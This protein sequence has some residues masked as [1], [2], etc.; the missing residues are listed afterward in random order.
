MIYDKKAMISTFLLLI[1]CIQPIRTIYSYKSCQHC[2]FYIKPFF[3][4]KYEIGNYLGKCSKFIEMDSYTNQS[5][6]KYALQVRANEN[7]CGQQGLY[8]NVGEPI[9]TMDIPSL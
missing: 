2:M 9:T 5:H 8:Y 6:Y 1:I 3:N 4:D 7:E